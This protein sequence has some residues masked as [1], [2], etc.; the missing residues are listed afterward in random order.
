MSAVGRRLRILVAD[1]DYRTSVGGSLARGLRDLGHDVTFFDRARWPAPGMRLGE[2]NR[3]L[4]TR[5]ARRIS[6]PLTGVGLDLHF[7]LTVRLR[8]PD[9]VLAMGGLAARTAAAIRDSVRLLAAYHCDDLE[10]PAANPAV[11]DAVPVFD[12]H[13]SP[14]SFVA[15]EFRAR[16]AKRYE[17]LPF[18]FDPSLS[19]PVGP[20]RLPDPAAARSLTF[21]GTWGPERMPVIEPVAERFPLLVWGGYWERVPR[22]SPAAASLKLATLVGDELR[23]VLS[24]SAGNLALLRKVNRDRHTMRTFEIPACGGFMLAERTEDHLRYYEDSKEAV[25][26]SDVDELKE[27]IDRY[28]HDATARRRIA[29][30]GRRR[31]LADGHTYRDRAARMAAVFD[32][33]L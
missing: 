14:R 9:V 26:F 32:E 33:L 6:G 8:R 7:M 25:L 18:G 13:F 27:H 11:R 1:R 22:S 28:L 31:V 20:E 19:F 3:P 4:L 2:R 24:N 10:N 16:G 29:E 12:V 30:A 5:L 15:D 23:A 21:V 17:H